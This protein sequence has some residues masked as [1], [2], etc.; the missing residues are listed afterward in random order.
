MTAFDP[1]LAGALEGLPTGPPLSADSLASIRQAMAE[2][3][4]TCAEAIGDR[5][6]VW[7][8]HQVPG[9]DVIVTVV[10]PQD[11]RDAPG[12]YNIHGGGMVLDDRFADLPRM[13][14][15]VEEF[16]FVAVTVDYRLAPEHPHPAPIED[17]YAGLTWM[18]EHA[19]ELGF[20]PGRLIVGGGSAGGG[21]S[22]GIALLARDRGGPAL[23]G[24]LL[25]CPMIDSRNDSASTVEFAERGVWGREANEFGWRSLLNGQTSPYAVPATAEDLTG[26]PPAF[27]EVGAAEIFRDEDV[28]YA[29]RLWRAGVPT[30]LHVWA[31]AYHGFDRIAP[32]SEVTRAALAARASWLRRTIGR[33]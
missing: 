13:V 30:E 24:Q 32:D 31:G 28:D 5:D 8:D 29:R 3:N 18:V 20:D 14:A 1:E 7:E 6:L 21:L 26:L 15:L 27:I 9:T 16:G 23:A 11:A 12:F 2:G 19:A 17:C 25:L 10:K 22:A 4:L 33:A